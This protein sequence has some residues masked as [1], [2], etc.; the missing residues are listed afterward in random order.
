M[1]DRQTE[2]L[3]YPRDLLPM[4][5]MAQVL[6]LAPHPD[7]E[8]F[9]CGGLLALLAARG[10][11]PVTLILTHGEQGGDQTATDLARQRMAESTQ[12]ARVLGLPPPLFE[13]F[14]DRGLVYAQPLIDCL[15]RA[16]SAHQP[17]H[18]LVPALSEPHP[19]HQA[20]ALAAVAAA[21][22]TQTVRTL[23]FYEVG[24]PL[25][26]NC[27]LDIT[28]VATAKWQAVQAFASQLGVQAYAEHAQA[29]ASLRAYGMPAPCTAA[30]A[31]YQ[32]PLSSLRELGPAAALPYWP[33][34]RTQQHLA[35]EPRQ[36]PLVSVLIRS[37]DR[38]QL[39]QAIAS[40]AAQTYPHIEIILLNA[41]GHPH[42]PPGYPPQRLALRLIDPPPDT[43]S[44]TAPCGRARAANLALQAC[45]GDLALFLDDDDLLQA[46]HIER[47]V[48]QLAERS[49]AIAAYAGVRVETH[50]GVFV[51]NYDIPWSRERL[52]GI[53][54]LPIHAVLFR[55]QPVRAAQARF[56]EELPVLEDWDFWC[57]IAR[58]G[59]MV[60]CP[61]V[62]A[63]YRQGY[64]QSDLGNP[65]SNNYWK[66]WHH[67]LLQRS[68]AQNPPETTSATLAWHAIALDQTQSLADAH[69]QAIAVLQDQLAMQ[70]R[71]L[72]MAQNE[73]RQAQDT[74]QRFS[75]QTQADWAAQ[76]AR[77]DAFAN[78]A[79][80]A[81]QEK[82][83]AIEQ[84]SRESQAALAAQQ[85][86]MDAFARE[87]QAVLDARQHA[88]EAAAALGMQ[89]QAQHAQLQAQ[90]AATQ[91]ELAHVRNQ[92]QQQQA[93][94][95]W[96]ATA[97]L[98][99]V[100]AWLRRP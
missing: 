10:V 3:Y 32:V 99:V 25:H 50:D 53:N 48:Q 36:L 57:Q 58:L 70:T 35:T 84:F 26:P 75:Q 73:V 87:A 20:L 12:A 23:V 98:R 4:A 92:L 45:S 21:L 30:E 33:L 91:S 24:A 56:D 83:R 71:A 28:P 49:A 81:L 42:S 63:V 89:L 77:T 46:H 93:S 85:A 64:G 76:Q 43:P 86:R 79:Q 13:H 9:G 7:D 59:D 74:L 17:T 67:R 15:E 52:A 38:A 19:D 68:I 80:A 18:L 8:V 94:L 6:C 31:Y 5:D 61:G 54:F 47:L 2:A 72:E 41:S 97:P 37:M 55:V 69:Q 34:V 14:P 95:S 39:P 90:W 82:D 100:R 66:H 1:L 51:R 88:L 40:V 22:R 29:F 16:I 78:E 27:Y 65:E 60:H 62:S 96:R 44:S 11:Q